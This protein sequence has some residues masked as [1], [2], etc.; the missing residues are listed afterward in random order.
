M[1]RTFVFA[2]TLSALAL[3]ATPALAGNEFKANQVGKQFSEASPGHEQGVGVGDQEFIIGAFRIK[4]SSVKTKGETGWERS[5]TL[6]VSARYK[7]CETVAHLNN[8]QPIYLKTTFKNA[9]D[10]E[11]HANG[12][13]ELGSESE[14]ETR[15]LNAGTIELTVPS[16]KCLIEVPPQTIPEKAEE[17]P[18]K[19]YSEV[20]YGNE[21]VPASGRRF[22]SGTQKQLLIHNEL[23]KYEYELSEGQCEEFKRTEGKNS[24]Y[25]GTLKVAVKDGNLWIGPEEESL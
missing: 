7:H 2:V 4:C 5:K 16:I 18:E 14:S 15:L 21:E 11:Y 8:S 1:K 6:Y 17:K 10:F 20:T 9:W 3:T 12:F 22:P 24:H 19:E 13:A 25:D 23:N